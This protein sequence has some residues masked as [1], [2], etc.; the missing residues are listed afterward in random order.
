MNSEKI[1]RKCV[2]LLQEERLDDSIEAQVNFT[3]LETRFK[4][5]E[6]DDPK[7]AGFFEFKIR[8]NSCKDS[9]WIDL[10]LMKKVKK[11]CRG[12]TIWVGTS[13]DDAENVLTLAVYGVYGVKQ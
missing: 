4:D 7:K 9:A 11:L 2:L 1:V 13:P 12:K 3:V 10:K 8:D 6:M 5:H